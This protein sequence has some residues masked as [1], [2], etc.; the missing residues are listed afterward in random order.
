MRKKVQLMF[1]D[2]LAGI[3]DRTPGA[4]AAAVMCEDGIAIDEYVTPECQ[5]DLNAVTVE[6]QRVLA[7]AAKVAGALYGEADGGLDELMLRTSGH[8]L[9]FH[10][11]DDDHF[12]VVALR[13]DGMLGKARY[14]TR[15]ALQDIRKEL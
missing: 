6:F 5:V 7:Q 2:I 12:M 3:V 1:R 4:L 13:Q 8:Q 14:L 10:V 11:I 15:M 9:L